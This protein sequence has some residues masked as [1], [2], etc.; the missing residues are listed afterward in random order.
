[1]AQ[2]GVRQGDGASALASWGRS[3]GLKDPVAQPTGGAAD[4]APRAVVDTSALASIV[5]FG[6]G[7]EQRWARVRADVWE[8]S[9]RDA[10]LLSVLQDPA[11]DQPGA[12]NSRVREIRDRLAELRHLEKRLGEDAEG[13]I[14]VPRAELDHMVVLLS[15]VG[16]LTAF[17]PSEL[18]PLMAAGLCLFGG[19]AAWRQYGPRNKVGRFQ[20][21]DARAAVARSIQALLEHSWVAAY[22]DRVVEV[23]PHA[24]YFACRLQDLETARGLI[25]QQAVEL[26]GLVHRV[27]EANAGLGRPRDDAETA[28]LSRQIEELGVRLGQV[29]RVRAECEAAAESHRHQLDRQRAIAARRALST[30][31]ASVVEGAEDGREQA[32]AML[33]VDIAGLA[34]RIRALD[35]EIGD[36]DLELRAVLEVSGAVVAREPGARKNGQPAG[37]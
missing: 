11:A 25:E 22:G 13:D 18:R 17:A 6:E 15:A 37:L 35:V 26:K 9:L 4:Q 27:Q 3:L 29:D 24:V 19:R 36:A 10:N 2:Q 31:V 30:R 34:A 7:R 28:R 8:R 12:F 20:L 5:R 21:A 1:M 16:V 33:E 32:L 14:T 23:C